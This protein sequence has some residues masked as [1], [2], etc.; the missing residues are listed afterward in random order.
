VNDDKILVRMSVNGRKVERRVEPR[1]LLAD[2]LRNELK[3]TGTHVGCAHGVC[4]ACTVLINGRTGRSCI[5]LAVQMEG[6]SIE[7]VESL[8]TDRALSP[9]QQAFHEHHALQCGFCTP[10]FLVTTQQ[11]LKQN[12]DPTEP[13]IRRALAGN[14][15][16]CTGYVNIVRAVKSA[17]RKMRATAGDEKAATAANTTPT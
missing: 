16:R 6:A 13:E 14:L 4:G 15:C 17:A 3:L 7:T 10:G 8:T 9:L 11:L 1:L 12:P 2:F 5:A